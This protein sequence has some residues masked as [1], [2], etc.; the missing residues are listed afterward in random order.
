[1]Q[2]LQV[3]CQSEVAWQFCSNGEVPTDAVIGG[4][5]TDGEPLYIGR[6]LHSGAQTIGKVGLFGSCFLVLGIVQVYNNYLKCKM[7]S[8]VLNFLF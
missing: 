4:Q 5:T 7:L 6:V 2:Q 8:H 3:L 1:M